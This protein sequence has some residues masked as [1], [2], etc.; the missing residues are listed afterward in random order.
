MTDCIAGGVRGSDAAVASALDRSLIAA[1]AQIP[2]C[3]A[4]GCVDMSTGLLLGVQTIDQQP[5]EMRDLISAAAADLFQGSGLVAIE[6]MFRRSREIMDD[7]GDEVQEI[8][9]FSD[10]LLHVFLK[11]KKNSNHVFVFIARNTA[12]LG[13]VLS[14]A[15]IALTWLTRLSG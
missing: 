5:P 9:T 13:T 12:N 4:G 7:R 8:V 10:N 1:I 11:S 2:E 14:K 6:S 3:V 15:R